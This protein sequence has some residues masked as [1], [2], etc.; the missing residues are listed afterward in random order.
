[1][2]RWITK[3]RMTSL[4]VLQRTSN[5]CG[6]SQQVNTASY[7]FLYDKS[8]TETPVNSSLK[9][10]LVWKRTWVGRSCSSSSICWMC[11]VVMNW[12]CVMKWSVYLCELACGS[13]KT[14]EP[15]LCVNVI[16]LS[17]MPNQ[18]ANIWMIIQ[19]K[20]IFNK[21]MSKAFEYIFCC[22]LVN[23]CPENF[24]DTRRDSEK[25]R[26]EWRSKNKTEQ[27]GAVIKTKVCFWVVLPAFAA[28]S[29]WPQDLGE[30][31]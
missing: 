29:Y 4:H 24:S 13:N 8:S 21:N 22:L 19:Q 11:S 27:Q 16:I 2:E 31:L 30:S 1:M 3:K 10:Q 5:K 6:Q 20:H 14:F 12:M 25:E 28:V 7:I 23:I 18:K 17:S 9:W 15:S 26:K